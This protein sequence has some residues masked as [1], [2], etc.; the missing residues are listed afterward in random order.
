MGAE[1]PP[2]VCGKCTIERKI[3]EGGMATVYLGRHRTLGIPVAIKVLSAHLTTKDPRFAERF[4][5]EARLAARLRHPNIIS[6]IDSGHEGGAHY[7]VM[8]YID[9]PTC[10][11]MVE[12]EGKLAWPEAVKIVKQVAE[13]LGYAARKGIM[14]RD[15]NP[16]NIMIDSDGV[17][18]IADLGLAKEI[19]PDPGRVRLTR[20]GTSLGT[21]YYMSPEQIMSAKEVDVRSDIYSLGMTLYHLVCG[22]V[23]YT[24][25][26]FE[27]MTKH[28]QAPLPTPKTHVPK[29]P[30]AVCDV[31]KEMAAKNPDLRYQNYEDLC[32]DLEGILAGREVSAAGFEDESMVTAGVG[33]P[34]RLDKDASDEVLTRSLQK[35]SV[36]G[37]AGGKRKLVVFAVAAAM[38]A[39]A[40]ALVMLWQG[41]S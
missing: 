9:G 10:S 19:T 36:V 21:P 18:R 28:V 22:H 14:H 7:L 15:V 4:A 31:I 32:E 34:H 16:A 5:R 38:L 33:A 1:Q 17:A 3:G 13:G 6:V 41:P 26:A 37:P 35:T 2:V 27:I 29:L 39:A 23:P 25:T 20:T 11:Q 30:D 8:E 24:G 12:T 40:I